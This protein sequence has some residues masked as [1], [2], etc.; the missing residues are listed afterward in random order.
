MGADRRLTRLPGLLMASASAR[1]DFVQAWSKEVWPKL[2][3]EASEPSA[4]GI[5]IID[6][7]SPFT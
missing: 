7:K 2:K 3:F 1:L 6:R 5:D 4:H